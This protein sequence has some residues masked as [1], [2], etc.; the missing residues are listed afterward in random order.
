MA[1]N[2]WQIRHTHRVREW[3]LQGRSARWIAGQLGCSVQTVRRLRR[4]AGVSQSVHQERA[5]ARAAKARAQRAQAAAQAASHD[6]QQMSAQ[7]DAARAELATLRQQLQEARRAVADADAR[8]EL[9]RARAPR[10]SGY[11]LAPASVLPWVLWVTYSDAELVRICTEHVLPSEWY[12]DLAIPPSAADT[13]RRAWGEAHASRW[14]AHRRSAERD[15]VRA[16]I[17]AQLSH[18]SGRALTEAAADLFDS[19]V[20]RRIAA[21]PWPHTAESWRK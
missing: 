17:K 2:R 1:G 4:R 19:E 14:Q 9:A 20:E 16:Q 7:L 21:D 12:G 10:G 3:T 18:L 15:G 5:Q 11:A 6:L 13:I 8:T